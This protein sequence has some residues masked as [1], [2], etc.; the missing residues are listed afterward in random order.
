MKANPQNAKLGAYDPYNHNYVIASTTIRNTPCDITINPT[1]GSVAH[2]TAGSLEYMFSISGTTSWFIQLI[3]IGFGTSWIELPPYCQTG[4]GSQ[5]IYAR[6]QN[7]LAT[8]PRSVAFRVHYCSSY[9]DY[10]LT[11]GI[12]K[13][14]DF[15]ILTFGKNE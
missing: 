1:V 15:N 4:V 3:S 12:G 6:V 8:V 10:I 11:Q 7:N 9:V 5:D 14:I 2:N 13:K